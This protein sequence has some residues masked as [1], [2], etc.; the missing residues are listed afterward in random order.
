DQ[1]RQLR[2]QR[3][4]DLELPSRDRH[5]AAGQLIRPCLVLVLEDGQ[6]SRGHTR[7]GRHLRQLTLPRDVG[8]GGLLRGAAVLFDGLLVLLARVGRLAD[9]DHLPGR[10]A[11]E[12]DHRHGGSAEA[13]GDRSGL[14]GD[15]DQGRAQ[16]QRRGPQVAHGAAR[17]TG[18][19]AEGAEPA[20]ES[21][22]AGAGAADGSVEVV[23]VAAEG[24]GGGAE[25]GECGGGGGGAGGE[26]GE[27]AGGAACGLLK[28]AEGGCGGCG[29]GGVDVDVGA[30]ADG[31]EALEAGDGGLYGAGAAAG[32]VVDLDGDAD[33]AEALQVAD[34][35]AHRG[36]TGAGA[37]VDGEGDRAVAD[38]GQGPG[39]G[40][41][42]GL[43]G[44]QPGVAL[45]GELADGTCGR[46]RVHVDAD[47]G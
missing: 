40:G 34:G 26:G 31:A 2:E 30:D 41:D 8:L 33:G 20:A 9:G 5:R 44:P 39:H 36:D 1:G 45:G 21:G 38:R 27:G 18:P 22:H 6:S 19:G 24:A 46:R 37:V 13:G 3:T 14:R 17:R 42:A 10:G 47:G 23:H 12:S 25:R 28:V 4:E 43:Q 16:E 15:R 11:G 29:D 35:G 32:A 7:L